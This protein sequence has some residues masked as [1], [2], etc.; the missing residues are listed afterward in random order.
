VQDFA[1]WWI[2][3]WKVPKFA[4]SYPHTFQFSYRIARFTN[5]VVKDR[6]GCLTCYGKLPFLA[7]FYE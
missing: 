7:S 6:E 2:F 3:K 5:Y 1:L 4:V